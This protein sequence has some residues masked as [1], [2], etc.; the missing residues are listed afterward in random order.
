MSKCKNDPEKS[1]KCNEPSPKGK[2]YC[3]HAKKNKY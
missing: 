3:A 2:G 1:Y